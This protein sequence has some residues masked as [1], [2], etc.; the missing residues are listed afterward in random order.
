MNMLTL[1]VAPT[2]SLPARTERC[3]FTVSGQYVDLYD[4][5]PETI[6]ITDI[7][8]HLSQINRFNGATRS[9]YSVAQH[10]IL[11]MQAVPV[12]FRLQAL[13]H[14]ASEAYMGDMTRPVKHGPI[15]MQNYRDIE[16]HL[17]AVIYARFGCGM[18]QTDECRDTI[19]HAD[20]V[21]LATERRDLCAPNNDPW[22]ILIGIKPLPGRI[23]PQ[24]PV[25]SE[26]EFLTNFKA[27]TGLL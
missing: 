23:R 26:T 2:R 11:V 27:L 5:D 20:R 16:S 18:A 15:D 1:P 13:L 7:A 4:P 10:S 21:V 14:D 9:T 17:Q 8:H 6:S 3:A 22:P 12:R 25:A 24:S 19:H